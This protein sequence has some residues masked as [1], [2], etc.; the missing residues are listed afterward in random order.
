MKIVFTCI[1]FAVAF[2]LAWLF[3]PIPQ[4]KASDSPGATA[5]SRILS[6]KSVSSQRLVSAIASAPSF[7][8]QT[9]RVIA[10][11]YSIPVPELKNWH[12]HHSLKS[13]DRDLQQLFRSIVSE[14]W[15]EADPAGFI[16][17][18]RK[19]NN[20]REGFHLAKWAAKDPQGALT[21]L[22][23]SPN[24]EV[25]DHVTSLLGN[26]V[27]IDPDAAFSLAEG[28]FASDLAS[29]RF[30]KAVAILA[31]ADLDRLLAMRSSWPDDLRERSTTAIASTFLTSDF[32]RALEILQSENGDW[33]DLVSALYLG[34]YRETQIALI[35]NAQDLPSGWFAKIH[36]RN[37]T[38]FESS[39]SLDLLES[40]AEDL[41]INAET[42]QNLVKRLTN[43]RFGKESR[44]EL[45][46][47]MNGSKLSTSSRKSLLYNQILHW[48]RRD[49]EGLQAWLGQ[50]TDPDL[51]ETA[52]SSLELF[53]RRLLTNTDFKNEPGLLIN[54]WAK[55]HSGRLDVSQRWDEPQ[56]KTAIDSFK[57]LPPAESQ[58]AFKALFNHYNS[59][60]EASTPFLAAICQHQAAQPLPEDFD[61]RHQVIW[62]ITSFSA[63]WA[64][65]EPAQ[66]AAWAAQLP[67]GPS[68]E[69]SLKNIARTWQ[70]FSETE[71]QAWLKTLPT[72]DQ[73][74]VRDFLE[75][76]GT[77]SD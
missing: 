42:H 69:W 55:G 10:L 23:D 70:G 36:K 5:S 35:K 65:R 13:L 39:R 34:S 32:P 58:T 56:L 40:S 38:I 50:L 62:N 52:D 8:D 75:P 49:R 61:Q 25:P 66:A 57:N 27:R 54:D 28:I 1:T 72:S 47:H 63:H 60:S 45:M 33:D 73:T 19:L 74:I 68:R 37:P 24:P 4:T 48:D 20:R 31:K 11:A 67:E 59:H 6:Q 3:T 71:T 53:D 22:K 15:L 17:W 26:L 44:P 12:S 43:L 18:I 46:A 30:P 77:Q 51:F 76:K 14:R 2:T 16:T 41:G 29:Y 64:N 9:H 7:E 21:F